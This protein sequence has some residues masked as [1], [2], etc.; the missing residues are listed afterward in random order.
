[1]LLVFLIQTTRVGAAQ[2]A[3]EWPAA[4]LNPA[5]LCYAV[6][7]LALEQGGYN[8]YTHTPAVS[9]TESEVEESWKVNTSR[10][11]IRARKVIHATNAYV[12]A[13]LPELKGLVTPTKGTRSPI[14][15]TTMRLTAHFTFPA[16]A[17]KLSVPPAGLE[18]FPRLEGSYSLRYLPEHF[19]SV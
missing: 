14:S 12:S 6:H 4:T 7:R 3:F 8:V 10:G 15:C 9:V 1:M 5:K 19:Y 16:Q 17:I 2:K 13:L 11:S 18:S